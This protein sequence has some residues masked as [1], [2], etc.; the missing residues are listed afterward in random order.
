[1]CIEAGDPYCV[2]VKTKSEVQICCG[3][4]DKNNKLCS[5]DNEE[6]VCSEEPNP[7]I[8]NKKSYGL[9]RKTKVKHELPLMLKKS[10]CPN[11]A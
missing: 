5:N 2:D 8:V 3:N 6:M 10:V 1:M 9:A 7:V 11:I 4:N